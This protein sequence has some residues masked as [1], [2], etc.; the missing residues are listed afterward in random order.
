MSYNVYDQASDQAAYDYWTHKPEKPAPKP[1]PVMSKA[2]PGYVEFE[3]SVMTRD[4]FLEDYGYEPLVPGHEAFKKGYSLVE[5]SRWVSKGEDL[6]SM[7][8]EDLIAYL[9][10]VDPAAL[11]RIANM[12]RDEYAEDE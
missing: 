11:V 1:S 12:I 10:E 8:I 3:G 6:N 4:R 2:Y 9:A 5:H 7:G